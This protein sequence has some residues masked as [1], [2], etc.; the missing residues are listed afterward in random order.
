MTRM[1]K[2]SEWTFIKSRN[3]LPTFNCYGLG[4]N[5]SYSYIIIT[6]HL[7]IEN[8]SPRNNV[9]TNKKTA[10]DVIQYEVEIIYCFS[11]WRL[12]RSWLLAPENTRSIQ[13]IMCL[14]PW[15]STWISFSS[16]CLFCHYLMEVIELGCFNR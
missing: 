14:H 9:H 16:F 12:I 1:E 11:I 5:Y 2:L 4:F 15:C 3:T 10:F 6:W 13:R 7:Y 8:V